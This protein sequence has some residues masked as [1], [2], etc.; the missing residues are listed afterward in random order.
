MKKYILKKNEG[1]FLMDVLV[2]SGIVVLFAT[3]SIPFVK[4][5]QPNLKL[6]AT[7]RSLTADLR[8]AQQL[9]ITEQIVYLVD[10]DLN[11]DSY[12]ILKSGEATSTVKTVKFDSE[13]S[14]QQIAGL[15]DDEVVFN[16]YGGVREPGQ[17]TLINVNDKTAIIN[18][19]PS[20][21]IKLEQ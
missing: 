19:K 10:F 16:F 9:T 17:I 12:Q 11:N 15:S 6:N 18:I 8:Y 2:V 13:V 14:F 7:A 4:Q 3:I 21:Y 20:G 1:Y 5:Y